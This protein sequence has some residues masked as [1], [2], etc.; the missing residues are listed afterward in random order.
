MSR[1]KQTLLTFIALTVSALAVFA[2]TSKFT[3]KMVAYDVMRHSSK[4]ASGQQNQEVVIL[5]TGGKQKYVKVVFSGSG[6]TLIDQKYFD[7]SLPLDVEAFRDHGCD[8]SA[9]RMVAQVELQQMGG[10]YLLTDAFK[11]QPPGKIK[12]LQCYDAIEKKKK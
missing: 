3:G 7:G 4:T 6:T 11:A 1:Q 12:T 10:T 8:E 2:R 5:E 9:P